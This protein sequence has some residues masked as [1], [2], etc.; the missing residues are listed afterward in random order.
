MNDASV[1]IRIE[2]MS[3]EAEV[4]LGE[5]LASAL[6]QFGVEFPCGGTSV[7]GGCRVRVLK[8]SLPITGPDRLVFSAAELDDGWRLACQA[9]AEMPFTLECGQW[10]MDILTDSSSISKGR[11]SGLGIAIDLGTTTIA[12]Q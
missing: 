11:K 12:A 3:V 4:P 9:R 5:S 10:Q 7:C 6:L 1:R 8:G 2:P